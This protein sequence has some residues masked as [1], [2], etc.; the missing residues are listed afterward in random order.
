MNDNLSEK[1]YNEKMKKFKIG[2]KVDYVNNYGVLFENK[3]IVDID[4]S[5]KWGDM[6]YYEPSDTPWMHVYAK[7]LHIPGTYISPSRDLEL[8]NGTTAKFLHYD[9]WDRKIFLI[10][11]GEKTIKA[12][13]LDEDSLYSIRGDFGEPCCPLKE[14]FQP[15]DRL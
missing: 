4:E 13:D 14:E 12:V 2:D 3:T 9:D 11:T 5:G 10:A 1:I 6:Y 15:K 8:Q 7:N